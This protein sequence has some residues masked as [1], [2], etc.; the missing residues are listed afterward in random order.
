VPRRSGSRTRGS[1][2]A[3]GLSY[4][5]ICRPQPSRITRGKDHPLSSIVEAI[6]SL[7]AAIE[8]TAAPGWVQPTLVGTSIVSAGAALGAVIYS[9]R[10]SRRQLTESRKASRMSV[11]P[12]LQL[13]W[14]DKANGQYDGIGLWLENLGVGPGIVTGISARVNGVDIPLDHVGKL[15]SEIESR[16][17]LDTR[18]HADLTRFTPGLRSAVPIGWRQLM[19]GVHSG[20][21]TPRETRFRFQSFADG[22]TITVP[23][24]SRSDLA[25]FCHHVELRLTYTSIYG[26]EDKTFEEVWPPGDRDMLPGPDEAPSSSD[27]DAPSDADEPTA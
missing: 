27:G 3:E 2:R 21:A 17:E 5:R 12:F 8:A 7:R 24:P 1:P 26:E 18:I 23:L 14:V 9:V 10:Q 20:P 6:A 16:L 22:P 13:T 15:W 4:R 25:C 11:K 19:W